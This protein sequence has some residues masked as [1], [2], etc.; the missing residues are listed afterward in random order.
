M[1]FLFST[2]LIPL[3]TIL[4]I[5]L[6]SAETAIH[7]KPAYLSADRDLFVGELEM[8]ANQ[9]DAIA[10]IILGLLYFKGV[11]GVNDQPPIPKDIELG[12]HW[13]MK[14]IEGEG[15]LCAMALLVHGYGQEAVATHNDDEAV[16]WYRHAAE[17]GEVDSQ[18]ELL[19][20][21]EKGLY[22]PQDDREITRWILNTAEFGMVNS[23]AKAADVYLDGL[24]IDR[25]PLQAYQW[26]SLAIAYEPNN[27]EL[28]KKQ[29]A[30]AAELTDSQLD[31]AKKGIKAW[32][33]KKYRVCEKFAE[34]VQ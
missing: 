13:F 18:R 19:K 12:K 16:A 2:I 10:Q 29:Q 32:K 33:P 11:R 5:P 1:K 28:A 20:R 25:D 9:G 22:T 24:V 31:A 8:V 3:F 15:G 6:A 14:P 26:I 34:V 21:Y 4:S 7:Q 27:S 30:I 17:K 23:Y